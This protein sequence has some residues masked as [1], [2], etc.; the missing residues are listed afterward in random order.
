MRHVLVANRGEIAVRVLRAARAA[1]YVTTAV[2]SEADAAALHVGLADRSVCVGPPAVAASYLC[3]ERIVAAARATGAD[4]V[5]PGYGMLAENAGFAQACVDAGLTFI[6]PRPE[7]IALMADKG[8]ARRAA[9]AV[10]VP[11]VPGYDGEDQAPDRLISEAQRIGFPLMVKAKA[12]GGGRGM[13]RLASSEALTEGLERA[14]SEAE[15]AFGDGRLMLERAIDGGRHVEIQVVGDCHGHVAHLGERDCSVQRRYQKLIEESPSPA[16]EASVRA[17]LGQAAVALTRACDYL[18]VGTVEFLLAED[19]QFYFLEM[20]TRL[21]VEHPVTEAV[22]GLDLVRLQFEVAEGKPLAFS[23][24]DVS[25]RG[26]AIEARVCTEDPEAGFVP[27]T[28][29]VIHFR[30]PDTALA[31]TDHCLDEGQLISPHYDSMVAKVVA[32]GADRSE[33]L[34]RLD[35]ALAD[36]ELLGV[37]HNRDY[38]RSVLCHPEFAAGHA[39]TSFVTAQAEALRTGGEAPA[40]LWALAALVLSD[41]AP[42]VA[43]HG[44][45]AGFSNNAET[46]ALF[47]LEVSGESAEVA[48]V[49]TRR[50]PRWTVLREGHSVTVEQPVWSERGLSG[51]CD[52]VRRSVT[53]ASASDGALWLQ[54]EEGVFVVVD[55]THAPTGLAEETGSGKLASGI[56]ATVIDVRVTVGTDVARG[57]VVAVLE[58]MKLQHQVIADMDGRVTAVHI[59]VGDQ[60]GIGQ[61]LLE[62]E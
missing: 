55:R 12:G 1:G 45:L 49:R 23:S 18:G 38:L 28:G 3:V 25:Y 20:N 15:A 2:Y 60:V 27:Q 10:G 21:Q 37:R 58:A 8:A 46:S 42:R 43:G 30:A 26:H 57:E 32:H 62:V 33:A 13:R 9:G 16:V 22:T 17:Q 44:G 6:G 61:M 56:E 59:A 11:C 35:R 50:P 48:V 19:G 14:R 41:Y 31:R 40:H 47:C 39:T 52:G 4:A 7:T 5:H 29:R 24:E 54:T 53:F 36:L 34:R 51:V